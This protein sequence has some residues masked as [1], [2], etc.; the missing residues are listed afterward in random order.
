MPQ[1]RIVHPVVA[2]VLV[3]ALLSGAVAR[4]DTVDSS[5]LFDQLWGFGGRTT[6]G[7]G[8]TVYVVTR[9]DDSSVVG[10]L[11]Y[12]VETLRGPTWIVFHPAVFPPTTKT[13]IT[14]SRSLRLTERDNLTIDGRGSYVSLR[15]V[16]AECGGDNNVIDIES[17]ENL[18]LTHLD[19]SRTYP[20]GATPEQKELCGDIISV[21]NDPDDI[22][23]KYFDRIWI[24]QSHFYDCG[25]ECIGITHLSSLR[26]A[27]LTISRNEFV[28]VDSAHEKG[29]LVGGDTD[30]D[31]RIALSL[32]QNRFA[33]L[34]QRLPRIA[35]G[36]LRAY[37]NVFENWVTAGIG[38][39]NNTRV[40]IEQNVF[41]VEAATDEAARKDDAW[42]LGGTATNASISARNNLWWSYSANSSC[43][44]PPGGSGT[45]ACNTSSFPACSSQGG[46]WYYQC[47]G[48]QMVAITGMSYAQAYY[49]LRSAVGWKAAPNDVRDP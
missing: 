35:N 40:M 38:A 32:Y 8:G 4:A 15:R 10:T 21:A 43:P 39:T 9:T 48:E 3:C 2:T 44:T 34:R 28:G 26:R 24:N 16:I 14:L 45:G 18:I 33:N 31:F 20:T 23:T 41:H 12:G 30:P 27:Y 36:Y 19:F 7:L 37:N 6:G 25:D 29:L 17:S 5:D 49:V 22:A 42:E 46:P 47:E 13:T 1:S 11:R